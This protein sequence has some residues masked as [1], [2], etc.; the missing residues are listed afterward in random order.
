MQA[1]MHT[2][3]TLLPRGLIARRR[4]VYT[5]KWT[6]KLD[7]FVEYRGERTVVIDRH[8]T[9]MGAEIYTVIPL[10]TIPGRQWV[11]GRSLKHIH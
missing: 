8:R 1:H 11:C 6:F 2:E 9:I 5:A 10:T 7:S 3:R 4:R